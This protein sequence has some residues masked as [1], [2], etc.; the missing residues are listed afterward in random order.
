MPPTADAARPPGR[1]AV[2]GDVGGHAAELRRSLI[3][4]GADPQTF[5]LPD[6]L[7]VVQVGD[8][9]H[10][11]PDSHGAIALVGGILRRQPAQWIQLAGNHEAQY[12]TPPMFHWP[13]R[14]DEQDVQ[15]LYGWWHDG[16]MGVAAAVAAAD[17]DWLITHA[18]LTE[19]FWRHL[20]GEPGSA[21]AA[22]DALNGLIRSLRHRSIFRPG[23]MLTGQ[24]D[25]SAGP[26]WA[27]APDELLPSWAA[28]HAPAPFDQI[29]GHSSTVHWNTG[30]HYGTVGRHPSSDPFRDPTSNPCRGP[31]SGDTV[32]DERSRHASTTINGRLIVGIDP[33]HGR[34]PAPTWAPLVV[35]DATVTARPRRPRVTT[36]SRTASSR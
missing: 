21:A 13:E 14:L 18:G 30:R 12:L 31:F 24:V 11:G 25:H 36:S 34:R 26:L 28:S 9:I 35:P 4:L 23:V 17:H 15:T 29:H 20:L 19:G 33:A 7:T 5:E 2:Y 6:D 3:E 22:A 32:E 16:R 10:R 1:V 27:S 8:L